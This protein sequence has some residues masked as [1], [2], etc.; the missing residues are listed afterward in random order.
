[1]CQE[2]DEQAEP[3]DPSHKK[4][5][6]RCVACNCE[7]TKQD[8][9]GTKSHLGKL[10]TKGRGARLLRART[11][12]GPRRLTG[13]GSGARCGGGAGTAGRV[14]RDSRGGGG[15]DSWR[16]CA[17]GGALPARTMAAAAASRSCAGILLPFCGTCRKLDNFVFGFAAKELS[18][19][20]HAQ[21]VAPGSSVSAHQCAVRG[22][23]QS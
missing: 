3:D 8:E 23:P 7:P 2:A 11:G 15:G 4:G 19:C 1:M 16:A 17:D 14:C 18:R 6:E 13:S 5:A 9:L 21:Q 22:Q 12:G 20:M 10:E